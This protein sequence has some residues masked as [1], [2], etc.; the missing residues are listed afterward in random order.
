MLSC[1]GL[2][3]L[4]F[5]LAVKRTKEIGIRKVLGADVSSIMLLLSRDFL[6]MVLL[7]AI[8]ASPLA[9]WLVNKWLQ[10]FAYRVDIQWW[11]FVLAAAVAAV[12]AFITIS[13]QSVKAALVNPVKSLRSE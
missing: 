13:L 3:S 12:I 4:A 10:G 7:S 2:F 1:S 6:K 8:I 5:F 11:V 9:W